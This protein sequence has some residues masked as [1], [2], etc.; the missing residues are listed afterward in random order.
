MQH[1][2]RGV[3]DVSGQSKGASEVVYL[4]RGIQ[5]DYQQWAAY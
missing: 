3:E 4:A 5:A 1:L 2:K